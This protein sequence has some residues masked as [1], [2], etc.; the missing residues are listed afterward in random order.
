MR[1]FLIIVFLLLIAQL[2]AQVRIGETEAFSTAERFLVQNR[3]RNDVSLALSE[4]IKSE[5]TG[6]S[7]LFV[8]SVAPQG[9]VIV[10]A[11]NEVLA[12]SLTSAMPRSE[13]LSDHIAYWLDL[14][15][16]QT[17]YLITHPDQVRETKKN[18]AEVGPLLTCC[19]GQ[20]CRHNM[21]CPQ[22]ENGPCGHV[23]A[24][25][26]AIAMAQTL[27]YNKLPLKGIGWKS[28]SCPPY[29]DLYA[30]FGQ[31]TYRWEEM[32]DT[33]HESNSAVAQLVSHCG[34]S[35]KMQYSAH[36]SSASSSAALSAL[37]YHFGFPFA[38]LTKRPSRDDRNWL[39]IIKNDLDSLRPVIYFGYSMQ[40]G[41]AFVCDG[42]DSNGLFHFNFGWDGVADG[43]YTLDSPYGF[44]G[45]QS[46]I[47]NI[48]SI[49][50]E[51]IQ[52]D[53]H[54]IIYVASDGRGDGSS[55]DD[56]TSDLQTAIFYSIID[57]YTIWVKQGTYYGDTLVN[58][59]F[60]I[61]NKCSI[62]GGFKGDEPFDYDLS[63]RDFDAH[64]SIL[65]GSHCQGV[66]NMNSSHTSVIDG[67][68]IQNGVASSGGGIRIDN[69]ATVRHCKV[70]NNIANQSGG[71]LS[72]SSPSPNGISINDCEFFGNEARNGGA[73]SDIGN[74][75]FR[76]CRIHDNTATQNGGGISCHSHNRQSLFINCTIN[77]NTAAKGGGSYSIGSDVVFWNCL[78]SNNTAETGGGCHLT[79]G[80]LGLYN[81]TIARNEAQSDYGGVYLSRKQGQ[82]NI[83]NCIVWGNVSNLES[84]QIGPDGT[85]SSC[86]V[87]ADPSGMETNFNAQAENDGDL[88]KFYVRFKNPDVVAGSEGRGGDFRLQSSSLCI[89]RGKSI[90]GQPSTD[91]DGQPRIRHQIV[92]L[93]AYESDVA[94]HFITGYYCEDDP[95]YYNGTLLAD[96]GT[97]TFLY[98][99]I[100]HDS[101]VVVQIQNPPPSVSI[102]ETLCE[103]E[104]FNFLDTIINEPGLYYITRHCTTYS[105]LLIEKTPESVSLKKVVCEGETYDFF[106]TPICE[107]GIYTHT[108]DCKT[109]EL[110]LTVSPISYHYDEK[111][112]CAGET[113][114]FLGTAL[115]YGGHYAG[116][117]GCD[118]YEL[119]LT[120][121]PSPTL[122]CSGDTLVEYGQLVELTASGANTY[123]WSTGDT[124]A[125]ITVYPIVDK[126]YT[127][128]GF[129][130][131]CSDKASATVKVSN[132]VDETV[133][134]PNPANH[135]VT[136]YVPLIDGVEILNIF[137]LPME[138]VN[139]PREAVDL[140]VS[141][142]PD[143]VYVVHIKRMDN[144]YY[145]KLVIRH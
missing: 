64:P 7:N 24:G 29:G 52:A 120:V 108:Q 57:D 117:I 114:N 41:H 127:V 18:Q 110:D 123:L 10:S 92:D 88:P 38:T 78:F 44:S 4:E 59:A 124:T 119:D 61:P 72:F 20:G 105:L 109:Y 17:D 122:Q 60:R 67:F 5:Q 75:T 63:L 14:Y 28:Y 101:L 11:L 82:A 66:V 116:V 118:T 36:N 21:L 80:N 121:K 74:A 31:T 138:C 48:R 96:L 106:G 91:L 42:Y 112:I 94:V 86:A 107:T 137:G 81:C 73:I 104:T 68:T 15:N 113:Y 53:E 93:G 34:I 45:N 6:Q 8:F 145:K 85:Y 83:S 37:Q 133:L 134:F 131:G 84:P 32:A 62:Y 76:R 125:S 87:E 70:C 126:T 50:S 139:T 12:Y 23:S 99:S 26:V 115:R 16:R 3:G 47:H 90:D 95:Y 130:N 2:Q 77:N 19:W 128:T 97:Y 98:P 13:D 22:D 141:R 55:W 43:Y 140:D 136:I 103:G 71:G 58:Y 129:R 30:N 33:L 27:Y 111:E 56:A 9:F 39:N 89:N 144:H 35:V 132:E 40:G 49:S 79:N 25:C 46:I 65:D 51:P 100:I 135:K 69:I 1:K 54:G 102:N 142:Y 143:G